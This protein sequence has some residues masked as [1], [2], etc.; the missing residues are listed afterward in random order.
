MLA[1]T[2]LSDRFGDGSAFGLRLNAAYEH[3]DPQ[4]YDA[5]GSRYLLALAGDWRIS[6]DTLLEAEIENSP[7]LA[8]QRA[9]LQR[10]GL[11]CVPEPRQPAHQP[12]QPALVAAVGVRG[13]T[14]RCAGASGWTRTGRCWRRRRRSS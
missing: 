13:H 10:A 2:D 4:T 8:A 6:A 7:P 1:A 14:A 12:E 3:L 11:D 9:G 5:E